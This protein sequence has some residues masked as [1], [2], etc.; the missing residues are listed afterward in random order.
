MSKADKKTLAKHKPTSKQ[1]RKLAKLSVHPGSKMDL[2][3]IPELTGNSWQHAVQSALYRPIKKQVTFRLDADV[4]AWLRKDGKG[5]QT[6][7]NA[8]LRDLMLKEL[9]KKSD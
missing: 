1:K 3:D 7:A 4:I 9:T 2:P 6:K 8:L 5:Y